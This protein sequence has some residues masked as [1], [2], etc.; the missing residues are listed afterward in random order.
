MWYR[1]MASATSSGLASPVA[2]R[3]SSTATTTWAASVSKWRR[4][5][6]RVSLRPKPSVP[7]RRE[8][9]RDPAGHL[10][11]DRLHEVGH[12]HDRAL[13]GCQSGRDIRRRRRLV[14]VKP[15][16]ALHS[17]GLL[18]QRLVRRHRPQFGAHVVLLGQQSLGL[19]GRLAGVP[20][21]STVALRARTPGAGAKR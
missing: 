3:P 2:R 16:V 21:N 13:G 4:S 5:A 8:V 15:V 20:L 7:K 12:R 17:E 11:G 19:Q 14:G 18:P 6:A 1:A 9:A 10:V